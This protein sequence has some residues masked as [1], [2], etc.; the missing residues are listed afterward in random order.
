MATV[1][2]LAIALCLGGFVALGLWMRRS[3]REIDYVALD[4]ESH[5]T[6]GQR[7]FNQVGIGITS[8]IPTSF[9]P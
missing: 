4:A 7:H 1:L 9:G 2:V 3:E 6:D 8:N 5:Q